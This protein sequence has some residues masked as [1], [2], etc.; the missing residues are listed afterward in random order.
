MKRKDRHLDGEAEE[1]S[2][3]G[4]P[5][6]VP[7][8]QSGFSERRELREIKGSPNEINS[9]KGEQHR[10]AA[11][12]R[13]E[14]KFCRGVVAIFAAVDFDQ[15]ERRDQA[16]L[17]KQKPEN[18]ILRGEGAVERGLHDEHERAK[19]AIHPLRQKRERKYQRRQ[20]EQ[21]Q[22]QSVDAEKIFGAD[23]WNP[24]LAFDEL[25]ADSRAIEV[26]P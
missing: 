4:E 22:T 8:K 11:Q 5:G 16:H 14:E 3:E 24:R 15:E 20:D 2:G 18:E 6:D 9:E 25:Q 1:D 7:V 12:E 23:R 10:D 26:T 19:T 21:E 17:V 13:V